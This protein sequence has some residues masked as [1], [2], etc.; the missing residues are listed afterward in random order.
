MC[1]SLVTEMDLLSHFGKQNESMDLLQGALRHS[2]DQS[3]EITTK[4]CGHVDREE[5]VCDI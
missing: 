4:G 2:E 1:S 3:A 5:A